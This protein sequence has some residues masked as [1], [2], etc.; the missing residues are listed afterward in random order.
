[1]AGSTREHGNTSRGRVWNIQNDHVLRAR[2]WVSYITVQ[3][4]GCTRR[5]KQSQVT[6]WVFV[7]PLI[8]GTLAANI[9]WL[10][11]LPGHSSHEIR[12]NTHTHARP[13]THTHPCRHLWEYYKLTLTWHARSNFSQIHWTEYLKDSSGKETV[14]K[15]M[16]TL[17]KC[18]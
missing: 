17:G 5:T 11:W 13:H 18:I 15:S 4:E 7:V 2:M 1:M 8:K 16:V 12:M 10:Q 3:P 14:L 9:K 6:L